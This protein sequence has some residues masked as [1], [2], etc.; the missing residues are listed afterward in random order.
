MPSKGWTNCW[1][2]GTLPPMGSLLRHARGALV[3]AIFATTIAA[4][5]LARAEP[6]P[7]L[8][9]AALDVPA[10][11][12]AG[13]SLLSTAINV[14]HSAGGVRVPEGWALAGVLLGTGACVL[15]LILVL[16]THTFSETVG[17]I[18][19][20]SGLLDL[21]TFFWNA[22]YPRQVG[23]VS[24]TPRLFLDAQARHAYGASLTIARF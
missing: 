4:P 8:T 16:D 1:N 22:R 14:S 5:T 9:I 7:P 2:P 12:L 18:S 21:G 19:I 24:F 23:N 13:G 20:G 17:A 10:L 11:V 6:D 15:G 3:F